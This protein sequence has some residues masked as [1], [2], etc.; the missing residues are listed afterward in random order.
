MRI[1]LV[2]PVG[3][4]GV[5]K[6]FIVNKA[7]D[8]LNKA[9]HSHIVRETGALILPA[10]TKALGEQ[11]DCIPEAVLCANSMLTAYYPYDPQ[12]DGSPNK[13]HLEWLQ[14]RKEQ[15]RQ[16]WVIPT[17]Q[18][19]R[20]EQPTYVLGLFRD[21]V[22]AHDP[23]DGALVLNG[24]RANDLEFLELLP[25]KVDVRIA[26]INAP[27]SDRKTWFEKA[28]TDMSSW[29]KDLERQPGTPEYELREWMATT[30]RR[31]EEVTNGIGIELRAARRLYEVAMH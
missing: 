28:K 30:S 13:E 12:P 8:L 2:L 15:V 14:G 26:W 7:C 21:A 10:V 23:H 9:G 31:I 22:L 20:K 19:I 16:T 3:Y 6:T 24:C 25:S 29:F 4:N 5:G 18:R 27:Y 17:I 1:R 11:A